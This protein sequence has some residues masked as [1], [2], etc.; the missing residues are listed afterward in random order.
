M[1][2]SKPAMIEVLV[3]LLSLM[4]AWHPAGA[5]A[6]EAA[7]TVRSPGGAL[8]VD[9]RRAG[10]EGLQYRVVNGGQPVVD[11]SPM[12]VTLGW[13]EWFQQPQT[14]TI[15]TDMA[16][17]SA[18]I[19][20]VEDRFTLLAGKRRDNVYRG[21][22]LVLR[23]LATGGQRFGVRVRAYDEGAAFRYEVLGDGSYRDALFRRVS[24]EQTG[25]D[26]R[27]ATRSYAG[28]YDNP[29]DGGP[30]YEGRVT[31]GGDAVGTGVAAADGAG[32]A[33]P[34][35]FR[36]PEGR[37]A[38][39]HEAGPAGSYAGTHIA[40]DVRGTLYRIAFPS[41][42]EA[43]G[44]GSPLP[45]GPAPW[46]MPWR[47]IITGDLA[48]IVRSTLVQALNPP[49]ASGDSGWVRPGLASWS[50]L[51][52]PASSQDLEKL[53]A[54]IDLAQRF[55]WPYCAVDAN[56]DRISPTSM[57]DLV[58]YGRARGVGILFWYNSAGATNDVTEGPRNRL[59]DPARRE[60]E[61]ARLEAL[62]VAGLKIDFWDSDKPLLMQQYAGVIRDAARHHLLLDLHGSTVPRGWE[63]TYPNLVAMEAIRGEEYYGFDKDYP[64]VAPFQNALMPFWRGSIGPAD[65]SPLTFTRLKNPHRTT[66][67]H[68]AALAIVVQSGVVLPGDSASAYD[69][70]P[71]AWKAYLRALPAA[72]DDTR[73]V[74]GEPGRYAVIA[75]RSGEGWWIGGV[76][77]DDAPLTLDLDL[78]FTTGLATMLRDTPGGDGFASAARVQLGGRL[79]VKLLAHGGFVLMPG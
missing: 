37:W 10:A 35:L 74:A 18:E 24:A 45:A 62:G 67:A 36:L 2:T 63:R 7:W 23:F 31:I 51:T 3:V 38:L 78:S 68:E 79:R 75:R 5:R 57:A 48:T 53:K 64:T 73:L 21:N 26:M 60:E 71:P 9:L 56:W 52:D 29:G 58:A 41:A 43:N 22:E 42:G 55:G 77:G 47:V 40:G 27:A 17:E 39:L 13:H 54:S 72:W 76:S 61:F 50:W 46:I 20:A 14:A 15:G 16:V 1:R 4:L 65:I 49:A 33:M 34:M 19:H 30:A 32:W 6:E 66:N 25:F 8:A 70:L 12:G 28:I 69:A 11:W 59:D 44:I